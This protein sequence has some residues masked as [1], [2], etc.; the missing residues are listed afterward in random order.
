MSSA[1][2]RPGIG[3]AQRTWLVLTAPVR[4]LWRRRWTRWLVLPPLVILVLI[5]AVIGV[6]LV[7]LPSP[8]GDNPVAWE[9]GPRP[10][11]AGV[12]APNNALTSADLLAADS[13]LNR[14]EDVTFDA[15]GRLYTG[16]ADGVVWRLTLVQT[17]E[18]PPPTGSPT[19]AR[20]SWA[21][22]SLRTG[23][24]SPPFPGGG[25]SP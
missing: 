15:Q 16:T 25:C 3:I 23:I 22:S 10:P 8:I 17:P 20:A 19:S 5:I 6:L 7:V 13:Q 1:D 18:S 11:M 9:P 14:P 21:C 24:S 12:L 4:V 2:T